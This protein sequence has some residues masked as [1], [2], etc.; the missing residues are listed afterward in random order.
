M[1]QP[2]IKNVI[3]D[4]GNVLV[5]WSPLEIV[6]L[7]FGEQVDT[8]EYAK[9]IFF[10]D[11]WQQLNKGELTESQAKLAYQQ[12]LAFSF[13]QVEALFYYIKETQI[14]IYGMQALLKTVKDTGYNVYALTDN[15]IEIVETLQQRYNFWPLFDGAIISAEVGCLKPNPD[16]YHCLLARY[17]LTANESVFIDD[18]LKNIEGAQHVGLYGIHFENVD[19]CRLALN[20]LGV[21]V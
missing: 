3:F 8:T 11:L 10:S 21:M 19:Q 6:K 15:V 5:R 20:E 13:Q 18:V 12:Q 17:Q 2:K 14:Q 1:N 9:R 7:T 16:I 4:I